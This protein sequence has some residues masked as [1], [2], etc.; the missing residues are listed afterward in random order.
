MVAQ[1]EQ[2]A[3]SPPSPYLSP[4][5]ASPDEEVHHQE[6]EDDEDEV[7]EEVVV[8]LSFGERRRTSSSSFPSIDISIYVIQRENENTHEQKQTRIY[9]L[10]IS[11]IMVHFWYKYM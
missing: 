4:K 8:V 5:M 10:P 7:E 1:S 3:R 6:A 11:A 2:D 9:T